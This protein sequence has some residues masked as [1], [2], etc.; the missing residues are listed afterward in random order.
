MT[1]GTRQWWGILS[2]KRACVRTVGDTK[3]G[4]KMPRRTFPV[5]KAKCSLTE[6]V[7]GVDSGLAMQRSASPG[8]LT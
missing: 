2:L 5:E 6:T 7:C 3:G 8:Y 1:R 4:F